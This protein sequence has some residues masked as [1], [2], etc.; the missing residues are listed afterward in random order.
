VLAPL[1]AGVVPVQRR[2]DGNAPAQTGLFCESDD[3][4]QPK[5]TP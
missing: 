1:S 2:I 3:A 5:R 4:G